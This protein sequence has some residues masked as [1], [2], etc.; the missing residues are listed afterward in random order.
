M[1]KEKNET[2]ERQHLDVTCVCVWANG[3]GGGVCDYFKEETGP[4]FD[5]IRSTL[6]RG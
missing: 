1:N 4:Y 5:V 2:D 6:L 3:W